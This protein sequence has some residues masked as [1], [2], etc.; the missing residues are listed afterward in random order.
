MTALDVCFQ[1]FRLLRDSVVACYSTKESLSKTQM[2]NG[3]DAATYH[4]SSAS[5][6]FKS[7][8]ILGSPTVTKPV[9]IEFK[10]CTIVSSTMTMM[11]RPLSRIRL[12]SWTEAE[13]PPFDVVATGKSRGVMLAGGIA[14]CA[15]SKDVLPILSC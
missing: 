6:N 8:D 1:S 3:I 2:E 10:N 4:S 7:I 12:E 11:D 14:R 13:L 15:V 5:D 9:A